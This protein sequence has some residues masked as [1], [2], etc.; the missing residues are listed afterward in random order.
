MAELFSTLSDLKYQ[1]GGAISSTLELDSLAPVVYDAAR[2]HILP[3][4]GAEYTNLVTA[5][6]ASSMSPAQKALL[7]FV[8]KPL[9]LLAM[10]EY[11][12]VGGI[13]FGEGGMH[14]NETET[15]K[16]V[17]RYQEKEYS[18]YM[19]EKGYEAIELLLKFLTDNA[20]TYTT[21]AATEEADMHRSPLLNYAGDFR[22]LLNVQC[23]RWTFECLRPIISEVEIAAVAALVPATFWS[24][25]KSRHKAGTLTTAEK[26]LRTRIR[27]AIGHF[28]YAEATVQHWVQYQAG[29]IM[30]MEE[31]G[32]QSAVNR[33]MPIQGVGTFHLNAQQLW[34]DRNTAHWKQWVV[35][36]PDEFATIFDEDS[37]G[38]NTDADAWHINTDSEQATADAE[39]VIRKDSPA[40]WL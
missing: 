26:E 15:K 37:G 33:T 18:R 36:N 21:W 28:A 24:G 10:Y 31:F 7:P 39:E 32:E 16:S 20:A 6:D 40:V 11:A 38:S 3:Y 27:K 22:R 14:R 17:Y 5:F 13:E 8:R 25:F 19:Q 4:M 29:R 9:A 35:D 2:R 30:V 12:K 1:V 34:A 23:D